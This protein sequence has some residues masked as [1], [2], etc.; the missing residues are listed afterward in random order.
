MS[1]HLLRKVSFRL[2]GLGN[3]SALLLYDP[4]PV[5]IPILPLLL[6]SSFPS[7]LVRATPYG[8]GTEQRQLQEADKS[9]GKVYRNDARI[10]DKRSIGRY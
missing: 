4:I 3:S 7:P 8:A 5:G 1:E 6:E 9:A 2:F 10:G